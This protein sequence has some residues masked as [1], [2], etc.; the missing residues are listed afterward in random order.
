MALPINTIDGWGFSNEAR[1]ELLLKKSG[2]AV[3]AV[4]Y[5]V[6]AV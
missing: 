1:H 2:S 4:H 3:F 5:T 6:K